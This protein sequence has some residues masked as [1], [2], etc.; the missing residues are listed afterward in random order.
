VRHLTVRDLVQDFAQE[1]V[2]GG[3][4]GRVHRHGDLA[5]LGGQGEVAQTGLG[6]PAPGPIAAGELGA[7]HIVLKEA[8]GRQA[9]STR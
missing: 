9:V 5:A 3:Q 1:T 8:P 4:A 2:G 6:D 7:Q